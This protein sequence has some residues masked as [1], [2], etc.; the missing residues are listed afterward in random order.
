MDENHVCSICGKD[1]VDFTPIYSIT[2]NHYDCEFPKGQK[3][4]AELIADLDQKLENLVGRP[5]KK[6]AAEGTGPTA[7]KAQSRA[8]KAIEMALGFEV[9][10][11]SIWNQQ[12]AY[13]G[14]GWDLDAW[15]LHFSFKD[16]SGHEFKGQA[17]SLG[18]MGFIV[19]SKFV[20]AVKDRGFAT[21]DIYGTNDAADAAR[22]GVSESAKLD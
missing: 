10:D 13:R 11:V 2:G 4:T 16:D 15:G 7:R 19:K 20:Y 1:V 6:R 22:H 8:I 21:F 17:S 3:S 5:K 9:Y 18:T 14:P 12:G